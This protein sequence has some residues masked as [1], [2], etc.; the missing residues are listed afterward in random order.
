MST[1][2][3]ILSTGSINLDPIRTRAMDTLTSLLTKFRGGKAL[4][5]DQALS[6]PLNLVT[7]VKVMR[8][9]GGVKAFYL[10][11]SGLNWDDVDSVVYLARPTLTNA[12][13]IVHDIKT[14]KEIPGVRPVKF[15]AFFVP[16]ITALVA[17]VL[18]QAE[19]LVGLETGEFPCYM[20]PFESD[21]LSMELPL[22]FRQCFVDG[23][24]APLT[25]IANAL[26]ELQSTYGTI[27]LIKGKGA[28]AHKVVQIMNRL[29]QESDSATRTNFKTPEIEQ[30]ILLDRTTDLISVS[31]T[32]QTYEGL[33]DEVIGIKNGTL[34][35]EFEVKAAPKVQDTSIG[36]AAAAG[37]TGAPEKQIVKKKLFLNSS[38]LIFDELRDLN[39]R[40][41]GQILHKKIA[42]VHEV[43]SERH[44]NTTIRSWTDYMP[45]LKTAKTEH[46]ILPYHVELADRVTLATK[47]YRHSR[48]VNMERAMIEHGDTSQ[49]EDYIEDCIARSEPLPIIARLLA[50]LASTTGP[51]RKRVDHI[52]REILQTYG[53]THLN[54]LLNFEALGLLSKAPKRGDFS[55]VRKGLKLLVPMD[56]P[57]PP[58]DYHHVYAGY[59]PLSIRMVELLVQPGGLRKSDD[60]LTQ[61]PGR[62]F[63]YR[64]ELPAA[65]RERVVKYP[66]Y[67][68]AVPIWMC[69]DPAAQQAYLQQK[70]IA[71]GGSESGGVM[72]SLMG[73]LMGGGDKSADKPAPPPNPSAGD[74]HAQHLAALL[75]GAA[76]GSTATPTYDFKP[77]NVAQALFG[78][79]LGVESIETQFA[80]R[81]TAD[82]WKEAEVQQWKEPS[83]AGTETAK[84]PVVLVVFIGGVTFAEISA[85]R[86]LSE[87]EGHGREYIILTT[88]LV[89]GTT[90]FETITEPFP[91]LL[92]RST[93][94]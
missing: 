70:G 26:L 48:R 34:E 44:Q 39:Y 45:K 22:T 36:A 78:Y 91:N 9:Q 87:R 14:Y 73:S 10:L 50:L 38:D 2:L 42:G 61:V 58:N 72:S 80:D 82:T 60:I 65:V 43:Y 12:N 41:L 81:K 40:S 59:A 64:Q 29:T 6:G 47:Q 17:R 32:Q 1:S 84:R 27:P 7:T 37:S 23:D 66:G 24:V 74:A 94:V 28:A 31:L 88:K 56:R 57:A 62:A 18:E 30:L 76:S 85:L 68:S 15:G 52:K 90:L 46:E 79:G 4:V 69:G 20:I 3:P 83:P 21:V 51:S 33:L 25:D 8:E 55:R 54:T 92:D 53:Y 5:I 13:Q 93:L 86:H 16:S 71:S 75:G 77:P 89:N 35:S 67:D 11:G 63:E 19:Q 49:F